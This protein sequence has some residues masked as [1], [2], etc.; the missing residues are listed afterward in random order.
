MKIKVR[1]PGSCGEL[2]QGTCGGVPFL[3]TCPVD[4]YSVVTVEDSK[5]PHFTGLGS[6]AQLA[7]SRTLEYLGCDGFPFD[8]NLTSELPIGKGMA[9]SS[10]D[11]AAVCVAVATACG[12][13]ITAE[14][15]SRL[16]AGIEPTD[17]IFFDGVVRINHMT[18]ECLENLG[19]LPRFRII[20]FDCGGVVDTLSFHERTDLKELNLDN[21][22]LIREALELVRDRKNP[23]NI[24]L[25][26]TKSA[27][28]NQAIIYK[29]AL[30]EL[31][32]D[33]KKLGALGI[34]IA[35]SGT[36]IGVL[37]APNTEDEVIDRAVLVIESCYPHLRFLREMRLISGG[38]EL[39]TDG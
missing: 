36:I 1:V 23:E 30:G 21:E 8:V 10:A 18:G 34:N 22:G 37:F 15:I 5:K 20:A 12:E 19:I 33:V 26:A 2:V 4:V 32:A 11:I 28:A 25:A 3:V 14:E 24:A 31:I 6:K 7:L 39:L 27:L 35:H 29:L 9:S 13:M 16:A 38:W 17:G